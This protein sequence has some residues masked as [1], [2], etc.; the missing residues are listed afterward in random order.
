MHANTNAHL[1]PLIEVCID[2]KVTQ[3]RITFKLQKRDRVFL[4][5]GYDNYQQNYYKKKND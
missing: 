5:Y 4:S 2:I 1:L 3:V